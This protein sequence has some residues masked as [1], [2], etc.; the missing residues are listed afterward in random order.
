MQ[1]YAR[2]ARQRRFNV[3]VLA[4]A[5]T[6]GFI[7]FSVEL[8]WYR[9]LTPLLGGS[10]YT[11]ALILGVALLFIGLGATRVRHVSLVTTALLGALGAAVPLMFPRAI[12]RTAEALRSLDALGFLG[13]TFGWLVVVVVVCAPLAFAA[14]AQ[15]PLLFRLMG[16]DNA[17]A[18]EDVGSVY[19]ANTIGAICGALISGF[20]LIPL[21]AVTTL[22]FAA[23]LWAAIALA[24]IFDRN[25]KNLAVVAAV[26]VVAAG[27]LL[28]P[29]P[30]PYF[31][32]SGIGAGR[33]PAAKT[34]LEQARLEMMSARNLVFDDDGREA[35][36]AVFHDTAPA[37]VVGGKSDGHALADSITQVGSAMIPA[38]LQ[39]APK[40][41]FIVGLG[42]GQTAGW[43]A[44][45]PTMERV[46]VVE[47]EP[48]ML[49][50]AALVQASNHLPSAKVH[51]E[52]GDGRQ[53]L[54]RKTEPYDLIISEPSNPY[55]AGIAGFYTSDFYAIAKSKLSTGGCFAQ[56][57]QGYE[58]ESAAIALVITTLRSVF[59]HVELWTLERGDLLMLACERAPRPHLERLST[60]VYREAFRGPLGLP[61]TT[62]GLLS[63]KLAGPELADDLSIAL[64]GWQNTDD[65]PVL[66]FSYAR[67]VGKR[68]H[69]AALEI[70][71]RSVRTPTRLTVRAWTH[72]GLPP[73]FISASLEDD[74]EIKMVRAELRGD[75]EAAKDAARAL[76]ENARDPSLETRRRALLE[77]GPLVGLSDV[78][79]EALSV[80]SGGP[81]LHLI[82]ALREDPWGQP[83]VV[84]RALA[85]LERSPGDRRLL[86]ALLERPFAAH[87]HEVQRLE[88]A[89]VWA[90]QLEDP[91]CAS[92]EVKPAFELASLQ[93]RARCFARTGDA[94]L[95]DTA[96]LLARLSRLTPRTEFISEALYGTK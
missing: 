60:K 25:R 94:A 57:V 79:N 96:D 84:A 93:R 31:R 2:E 17:G 61:S 71:R 63:R 11:F 4:V 37:V 16:P 47:L 13:L 56:W 29:G 42:T 58:V 34:P 6:S 81:P 76:V 18:A 59:P 89:R 9:L 53:A 54:E 65:R 88:I 41:A 73:P 7:F 1:S 74:S 83:L 68:D 85:T 38:L 49:K 27:V 15:L 36:L 26:V 80:L 19:A 95:G 78:D 35:A 3:R 22:R 40:R 48:A 39:A 23:I 21:S 87:V 91:R 32:H 66:E 28:A 67:A 70:I 82:R 43:L 24:S 62:A 30:G 64:P 69:R 14:G 45:V 8:V 86:D 72:R 50:F 90:D 44:R 92:L 51:V 12:A 55:R 52:V 77:L 20:V 5:F 75:L 10:T 46:D 33:G